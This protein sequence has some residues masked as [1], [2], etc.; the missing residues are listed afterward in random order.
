MTPG[1][2]RGL[3]AAPALQSRMFAQS[4]GKTANTPLQLENF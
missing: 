1:G 4:P 2:S 3:F